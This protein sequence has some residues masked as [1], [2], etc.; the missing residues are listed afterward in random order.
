[1][2]STVVYVRTSRDA[3]PHWLPKLSSLVVLRLRW[4]KLEHDPL[5][6]LQSL[7]NLLEPLV[8]DKAYDGDESYVLAGGFHM[9]L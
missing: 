4:N 8:L 9:S 2:P 7:S 3:L 6:S 1:M 5:E